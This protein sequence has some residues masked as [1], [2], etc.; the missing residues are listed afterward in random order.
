MDLLGTACVQWCHQVQYKRVF[1]H[2]H[3]HIDLSCR[4]NWTTRCL[5]WRKRQDLCSHPQVAPPGAVRY[6]LL[7][8]PSAYLEIRMKGK[9]RKFLTDRRYRGSFGSLL[10]NWLM[11]VGRAKWINWLARSPRPK[12]GRLD[13]WQPTP[14]PLESQPGRSTAA[15]DLQLPHISPFPLDADCFR[16]P[17]P[18]N[19]FFCFWLFHLWSLLFHDSDM[20]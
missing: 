6:F 10:L 15:A 5:R 16:L 20:M 14:E 19:F 7:A 12:W 3:L 17:S 18:M 9:L 11:E 2:M 13:S 8:K 4:T 1:M